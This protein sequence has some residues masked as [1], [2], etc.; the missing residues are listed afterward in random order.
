MRILYQNADETKKLFPNFNLD[1]EMQNEKFRK[2]L[3]ATGGDT[4]AA[5]QALHWK[6][7]TAQTVAIESERA[8]RAITNSIASGQLRPTES[9]LS[10]NATGVVKTSPSY[11]GMSAKEM[12]EY[13]QSHFR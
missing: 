7:L 1:A 10:N 5:Y 4:T 12:R 2:M 8:K 6:E 9:G 13:A 11:K 3:F